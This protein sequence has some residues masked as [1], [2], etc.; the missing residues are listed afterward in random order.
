MRGLW[1]SLLS[2]ALGLGLVA[3]GGIG[4]SAQAAQCEEIPNFTIVNKS[5]LDSMLDKCLAG[6]RLGDLMPERMQWMIRETGFAIKATHPTHPKIDYRLAE[7]TEKY[8]GTA[9]IDPAT[10]QIS[11]YI[12]GIPFPDIDPKDPLAAYKVHY[13]HWYNRGGDHFGNVSPNDNFS[14]TLIDGDRG[15]E[16]IQNWNFSV[17]K[18]TARYTSDQ[19]TLGDGSIFMKALLFAAYPH[20]IKGLGTYTIRHNGGKLDDVWAYIRSV[21]RVR[22][23]SGGA[24]V[25]PIGGTDELQDDFGLW[26]HPTWYDNLK[27]LGIKWTI[28]VEQ[29]S[30]DKPLEQSFPFVREGKTLQEQY[31][32]L[33]MDPPY[34]NVLD[35]WQPTQAYVI[36]VTPP[37]FHPYS[38]RVIHFSTELLGNIFSEAYDKK[39]D[40]WKVIYDGDGCYVSLDGAID[41]ETGKA[42]CVQYEQYGPSIDYQRRHATIYWVG[43]D[44]PMHPP[45][46]RHEQFSY[47]TLEAAG[48]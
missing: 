6:H 1:K 24:W 41:P 22:R 14:F 37:E 16:R 42:E 2:P 43:S 9:K 10:K 27:L 30:A 44:L 33:M 47:A 34:W 29:T 39:G 3:I 13:N 26:G 12:A 38:K 15:V 23:L 40:F 35:T 18:M 11:G 4:Q 32:L 20:D 8:K 45:T 46:M 25:D 36:E 31:P 19:H 17:Y 28:G 21:R 7:V 5:N 48:R